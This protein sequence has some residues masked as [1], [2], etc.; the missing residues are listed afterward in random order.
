MVDPNASLALLTVE[1]RDL[2]QINASFGHA[3]GEEVIREIASRITA[4]VGVTIAS[5][6]A[7]Q[8]SSW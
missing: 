3:F 7:R 8:H 5:H 1:V 2:D 6:A 4:R